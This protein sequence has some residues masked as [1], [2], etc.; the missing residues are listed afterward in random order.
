M[1]DKPAMSLSGRSIPTIAGMAGL[2][3]LIA[4]ASAALISP[5]D[6]PSHMGQ[7]VTVE[8]VARV[9]FSQHGATLL[10]FDVTGKDGAL[11][12]VVP[13]DSAGKFKHPEYLNGKLIRMT[14]QLFSDNGKLRI[15]L[16]SPGQLTV[17]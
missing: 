7:V 15:M 1:R 10:A 4:P 8:G 14:G 16:T 11:M 12:G 13:K 2:F 9:Q 5:H 6:A 17:K 3:A